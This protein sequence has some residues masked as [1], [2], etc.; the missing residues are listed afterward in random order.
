MF[1]ANSLIAFFTSKVYFVKET[2]RF[3]GENIGIRQIK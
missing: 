2:N 3:E 1:F